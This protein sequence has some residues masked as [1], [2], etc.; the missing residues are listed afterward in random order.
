MTVALL[1]AAFRVAASLAEARADLARALME[2]TR[3]ERTLA[4]QRA[5]LE[6]A[7]VEA[8]GGEKGLGSNET[9]QKRALLLAVTGHAEYQAAEEHALTC[10]CDRRMCEVD[11]LALRDQLDICLQGLAGGER[12][13]DEELLVCGASFEF[14]AGE[15]EVALELAATAG[16][17]AGHT[18]GGAGR[19]ER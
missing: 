9:A 4:A 1:T 11:L 19:D 2:S 8:A 12:E 7:A 3:A 13:L 6:Q 18:G 10:A 14:G 15:A 17:G 16:R 5:R